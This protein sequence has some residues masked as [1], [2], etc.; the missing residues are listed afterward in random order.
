[1]PQDSQPAV[2]AP[3]RTSS[4]RKRKESSRVTENADPLLPKNKRAKTSGV[5][6]PKPRQKPDTTRIP[7]PQTTST[8]QPSSSRQTASSWQPSVA[9][10]FVDEPEIVTNMLPKN[11]NHIIEAADGSD[12][13]PEEEVPKPTEDDKEEELEEDELSE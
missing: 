2:Q 8:Q 5:L 9:E 4:S 13:D 6:K 11:P 3:I 1:M 12:D 7:T 10:D